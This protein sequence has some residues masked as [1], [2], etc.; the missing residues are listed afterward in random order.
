MG[1]FTSS[2]GS[3]DLREDTN[4]IGSA[5]GPHVGEAQ[6]RPKGENILVDGHVG[7]SK[8]PAFP[9]LYTNT[10]KLKYNAQFTSDSAGDC[11][12]RKPRRP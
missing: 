10:S 4:A 2:D 1:S 6:R 3:F 12:F 7:W 5:R 9:P 8:Y 11:G